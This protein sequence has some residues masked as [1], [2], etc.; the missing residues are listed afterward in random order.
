MKIKLF[1]SLFVSL[2]LITSCVEAEKESLNTTSPETKLQELG[3][4]LSTPS[5][6]VANYVNTVQVGNLLFISGKGPL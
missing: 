1:L 6:P 2:L 5:S 3:V 4:E